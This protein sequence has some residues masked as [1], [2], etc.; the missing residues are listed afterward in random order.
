MAGCAGEAC[1]NLLQTSR[2]SCRK[3]AGAMSKRAVVEGRG[4]PVEDDLRQAE[5]RMLARAGVGGAPVRSQR[6]RLRGG[7]AVNYVVVGDEGGSSNTK[8]A[9]VLV[10]GFGCGVGSWAANYC[11]LASKY[12]VYSLDMVGFGRSSRPEF[13]NPRDMPAQRREL[14]AE[15]YFVQPIE[16]WRA[17]MCKNGHRKLESPV[18]IGHSFGAYVLS[19]YALKFPSSV[20]ALIF[21]DPWGIQEATDLDEQ[22]IP[23]VLRTLVSALPSPLSP[24]RWLDR[25]S[26]SL[27]KNSFRRAKYQQHQRWRRAVKSA[28]YAAASHSPSSDV[29]S[30]CASA[31]PPSTPA[32]AEQEEERGAEVK[33]AAVPSAQVQ[34]GGSHWR[35]C[36]NLAKALVVGNPA[37]CDTHDS[38]DDDDLQHQ[39]SRG[40]GAKATGGN[41]VVSD[42]LYYL[43]AV[44][45]FGG[46]HAFK[47][48]CR[49]GFFHFAAL[50]KER[51]LSAALAPGGVLQHTSLDIIYGQDTWIDMRVGHR[52]AESLGKGTCC[53]VVV[54]GAGHHVHLDEALAFNAHVLALLAVREGGG[55]GIRSCPHTLT[56]EQEQENSAVDCG[57]SASSDKRTADATATSSFQCRNMVGGGGA[58]VI[59]KTRRVN[60]LHGAHEN[61]E[62]LVLDLND[63]ARVELERGC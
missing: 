28:Q 46:D 22:C 55:E 37:N 48:L 3:P 2:A 41:F 6:V 53:V 56:A 43:A 17:L 20:G 51:P 30:T 26:A 59:G 12:V 63:E 23:S 32:A 16:H 27:G 35:W 15:D 18:W 29:A 25:A 36:F 1:Q 38:D 62:V 7:I 9:C 8:P 19:C 5:A 57:S 45:A 42:Y 61:G 10:H 40:D 31:Q 44:P 52:L 33:A 50:P 49:K 13:I 47:T 11:A 21:A 34:S 54:P 24:M 60:V 58:V 39:C 4:T 14:A